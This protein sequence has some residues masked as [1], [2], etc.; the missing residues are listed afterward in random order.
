MGGAGVVGRRSAG[1]GGRRRGRRAAQSTGADAVEDVGAGM[2]WDVEHVRVTLE[3][4]ESGERLIIEQDSEGRVTCATEAE[5]GHESS[6]TTE[7]AAAK[8]EKAP[9]GQ[10]AVKESEKAAKKKTA[11]KAAK[12]TAKKTAKKAAKKTTKK[13]A[14]KT[15]VKRTA[16]KKTA[17]KATKKTTKEDEAKA[18]SEK[19]VP[20]SGA[21]RGTSLAWKAVRDHGYEGFAA[22]SGAGVFKILL[23]RSN[24]W[25]LFL[26]QPGVMPHHHGCFGDLEEAKARAQAIHDEVSQGRIE[27]VTAGQIA[28]ACPVPEESKEKA[29]PKKAAKKSTAKKSTTTAKQTT[30]KK[31]TTAKDT[32]EEPPEKAASSREETHDTAARDRELTESFAGAVKIGLSEL[33]EDD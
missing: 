12:K 8:V 32:A 23:T 3:D 7:S 9:A 22:S 19:S 11:K 4:R 16:A 18:S 6:S 2:K 27:G 10:A 13:A 5:S 1:D 26:E 20:A 24:Q 15:A 17:K 14:K 33:D 25:A 21:K 29:V 30:T 31:K 28:E